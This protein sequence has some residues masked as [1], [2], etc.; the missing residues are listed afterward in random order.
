MVAS[1]TAVPTIDASAS[2]ELNTLLS[3]NESDNP[4]V[5]VNTPPLDQQYLHHKLSFYRLA[6]FL[7]ASHDL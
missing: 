1:P 4:L 3:P 2:G 5:A 7:H 6:S